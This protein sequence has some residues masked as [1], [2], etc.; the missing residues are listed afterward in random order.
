M[1]SYSI[2]ANMSRSKS[3]E[4]QPAALCPF[5]NILIKTFHQQFARDNGYLLPDRTERCVLLENVD[6]A[7]APAEEARCV[8]RIGWFW[9]DSAS[10]SLYVSANVKCK[11]STQ[12]NL[13]LLLLFS[14]ILYQRPVTGLDRNFNGGHRGSPRAPQ[15]TLTILCDIGLVGD[16]P[17]HCFAIFIASM[18]SLFIAR[19][20][21]N[22]RIWCLHSRN[23][24]LSPRSSKIFSRGAGKSCHCRENARIGPSGGEQL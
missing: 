16:R 15:V 10:F 6:T 2:L 8:V 19:N 11:L 21:C 12:L 13:P 23:E 24:C 9:V 18:A 3:G 7:G 20:H 4:Q 17:I 1:Q 14:G 5:T 22:R